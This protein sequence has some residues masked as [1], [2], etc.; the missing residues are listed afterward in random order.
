MTLGVAVGLS[1]V[2]APHH[3]LA[4]GGEVAAAVALHN[5]NGIGGLADGKARALEQLLRAAVDGYEEVVRPAL[6]LERYLAVVV[7]DDGADIEAVGRHGG[8][9]EDVGIGHDDGAAVGET[10]GGRTGGCR[11]DEPRRPG[12]SPDTRR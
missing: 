3:L 12:R 6:H 10:V 1:V 7:D 2:G 4:E 8:K 11:D 5:I 9:A